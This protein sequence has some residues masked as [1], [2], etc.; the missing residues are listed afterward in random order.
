MFVCY[1]SWLRFCG[2]FR[3]VTTDLTIISETKRTWMA[4]NGFSLASHWHEEFAIP[5]QYVRSKQVLIPPFVTSLLISIFHAQM[6]MLEHHYFVETKVQVKKLKQ[7]TDCFWY[8]NNNSWL[9]WILGILFWIRSCTCILVC[10]L[11]WGRL[12]FSW[13]IPS[14]MMDRYLVGFTLPWGHACSTFLTQSWKVYSHLIH[15]SR[16]TSGYWLPY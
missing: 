9:K 6:G 16:L 2:I 11:E 10:R 14:I 3:L 7:Q 1:H 12:C 4:L 8:D 15:I 5:H 13:S